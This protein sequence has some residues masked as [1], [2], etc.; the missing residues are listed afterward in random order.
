[1]RIVDLTLAFPPILLAMVMTASLGPGLFH[2]GIAM[3]LVWWPIYARLLRAQI[4]SVKERPHVEAA[5]AAGVGRWRQLRIHILP[6]AYH[7]DCWSTRP[8]TSARS[9]CSPRA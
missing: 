8:W 3:V 5:V 7:A 4:L 6:L 1:M 9:C 2:A